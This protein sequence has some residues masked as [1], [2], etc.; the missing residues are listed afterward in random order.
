[1]KQPL[2]ISKVLFYTVSTS[3]ILGA[4]FIFG[5]YSAANQT[6]IFR[7]L[8]QL[9]NTIISDTKTVL[10]EASTLTKIHPKHFLQ[11]SHFIGSDV[12]INENNNTDD[13]IF[14]SGFFENNN[15]LRL[16]Q[17]NGNIVA[18]WPVVFSD[19]FPDTNHLIKPPETDWNIDIHGAL[20]MPDGSIV[21]NFE[22]G[23]LVKLNHCG[24]LVWKL[25][26]DT[27]HSV[28]EAESGGFWV[29]GTKHHSAG[30]ESTFS[31]F[32]T[33]FSEDTILRISEHGQILNEISVPKLF[34]E[35]NMEAILSS[36]GE[37]F[38]K[39]K[40][41]DEELVHLNKI[42]ELSHAVAESFPL[43]KAGDLL[44]SLRNLNLLLVID[45]ATRLIKWWKIGPWLRQHDP[46]FKEGGTIL[47][48]NN[49]IYRN[50][51][52][53][54]TDISNSSIPRISNIIE[55]D[56]SSNKY[57]ILYGNKDKDNLLSILR[58]K[59][60]ILPNG[61]L[62][63]TEFEG[64][65]V[66]EINSSGNIIWEYINRYNTH[67]VAE[68]TEARVYPSSYFSGVDWSCGK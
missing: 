67:E 9:K 15:E 25:E 7:S 42:A 41:W 29:P 31:P 20:I 68:I 13:L 52:D 10:D 5:L 21:F 51:F 28:E 12:T 56:P 59:Q 64:G 34:Y 17:R 35:N 55:I 2:D 54:G 8:I 46:E 4:I 50:A 43:F 48:F 47:V 3:F 37:K 26:Y 19:I 38:S 58:G 65:R 14:L 45:P 53:I 36:T 60:D 44:L 49:N 57:N 61:N 33:P 22:H 30:N 62:L 11:P 40:Q 18:R 6:I 63:I 16:I 27:H 66:F 39:G 24:D 23:G 32:E 1:M